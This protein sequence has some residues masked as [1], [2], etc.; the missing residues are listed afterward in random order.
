MKPHGGRLAA[1][2]SLMTP[3]CSAES[4][5]FPLKCFL[6]PGVRH[7]LFDLE[8]RTMGYSRDIGKPATISATGT[9]SQNNG[10]MCVLVE[11]MKYG[12]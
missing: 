8:F 11:D 6:L 1:D 2:S 5:F 12:L 9:H 4:D 3:R 10:F 7:P